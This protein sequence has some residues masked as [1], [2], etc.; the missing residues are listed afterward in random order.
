MSNWITFEHVLLQ[1]FG[2]LVFRNFGLQRFHLHHTTFLLNAEVTK[3]INNA[4]LEFGDFRS[5]NLRALKVLTTQHAK[6]P[7]RRTDELLWCSQASEDFITPHYN[8]FE[9]RRKTPPEGFKNQGSRLFAEIY[10]H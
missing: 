5:S 3:Y 9:H 7:E 8:S 10:G 1:S 4:S 6:F 2:D